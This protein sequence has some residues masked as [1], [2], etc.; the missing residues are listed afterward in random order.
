MNQ[1]A[2]T[3]PDPDALLAEAK[4]RGRGRLRVYLGNSGGLPQ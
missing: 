2:P 3:R 4:R 1:D